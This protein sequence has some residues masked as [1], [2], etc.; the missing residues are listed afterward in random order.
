MYFGKT[1][2]MR[3]S[4]LLSILLL[5]QSRGRMSAR[6]LAAVL[7]VSVRTV[8]RDIEQL[9]A[10]GVPVFATRGREGGFALLDGWRT[11]LTGLTS[12]E[13][14]ALFL[15]GLPGPADALGLSSLLDVAEL[16]LLAALPGD[17]HADTFRVRQR[18]H[19]DP[20]SWFASDEPV[21]F[22]RTI[23]EATWHQQR[24]RIR[25]E[26][27]TTVSTRTINPLGVVLKAG[28]WYVVASS[29]GIPRTFRLSNVL[30]AETTGE[31]FARP[32]GFDLASFWAHH[33]TRYERSRYTTTATVRANE[34]GL[35]QLRR[36]SHAIATAIAATEPIIDGDGWV[37]VEIPIESVDRAADEL[38]R[39]GA[40]IEVVSPP[41]LRRAL[42]SIVAEMAAAYHGS[43]H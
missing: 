12:A 21:P 7:E 18:F 15:A 20:I 24:V 29:R 5:L 16:K 37:T 11:Q 43:T 1:L 22:L 13:S 2:R 30:H 19:L 26:S 28:V 39:F 10:A 36:S 25:Y 35:R 4:R 33:A 9:G 32:T 34:P 27:W 3:A 8:H 31:R 23:G 14:E 40:G 41:E 17:D 38:I 6:T 42:G